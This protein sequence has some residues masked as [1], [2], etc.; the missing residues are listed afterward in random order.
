MSKSSELDIY[1]NAGFVVLRYSE[2]I[3]DN[4]FENSVH[5]YHNNSTSGFWRLLNTKCLPFSCRL[6]NPVKVQNF[7]IVEVKAPRNYKEANKIQFRIPWETM[8]ITDKDTVC[9]F[10][11][12]GMWEYTQNCITIPR[13]FNF[14]KAPSANITSSIDCDYQILSFLNVYDTMNFSVCNK[15]C[16][17]LVRSNQYLRSISDNKKGGFPELARIGIKNRKIFSKKP[18]KQYEI[19]WYASLTQYINLLWHRWEDFLQDETD[20]KWQIRQHRAYWYEEANSDPATSDSEEE[21]YR[22]EHELCDY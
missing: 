15:Q 1:K 5:Y 18:L 2:Y 13:S 21:Y 6:E 20:M 14:T 11:G 17:A 7:G 22:L 4:E 16:L 12:M 3:R 9:K 19:W 10:F 8:N